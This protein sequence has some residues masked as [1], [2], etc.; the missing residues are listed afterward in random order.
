MRKIIKT[1]TEY[2]VLRQKA[3]KNI[4]IVSVIFST[5]LPA[6]ILLGISPSFTTLLIENTKQSAIRT[7]SHLKSEIFSDSTEIN[8]AGLRADFL[9]NIQ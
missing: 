8:K 2:N 3:L 5:V 7:A 1:L 4:L 6:Y 9:N